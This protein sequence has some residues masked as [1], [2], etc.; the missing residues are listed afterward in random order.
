ML[1]DFNNKCHWQFGMNTLRLH[2]VQV[3]L[4][5]GRML[6]LSR[7]YAMTKVSVFDGVNEELNVFQSIG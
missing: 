3:A 4:A 5:E 6:A 7:Q 2:T 1:H